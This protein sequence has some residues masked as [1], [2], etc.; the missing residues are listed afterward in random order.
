MKKIAI[1]LLAF[2]INVSVAQVNSNMGSKSMPQN[3]NVNVPNNI[4]TQFNKA[5]P[6]VTPSWYMD[7]SHYS[8][9]YHDTKSNM[10]R[11]VVYDNSGKVIRTDNEMSSGSYPSGITNY[12]TKNYP[13]MNYNVWSSK[14]SKGNTT[15]Y[16]TSDDGK[17]LWF[18]KNGT[19]SHL[20]TMP[21]ATK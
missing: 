19:Y 16:T 11:S 9:Y 1:L 21:D 15:Y 10:G 6:N 14:D 8:A 3:P 7:G 2:G 5:Y 13:N 20:E 4:S 18:D 12:Y 17:K